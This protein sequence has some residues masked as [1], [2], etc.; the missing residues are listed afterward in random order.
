[1]N[2]KYINKIKANISIFSNRKTY[3]ILD[4]TYKSVYRGKSMNFENLREYVI[5]D[6]IKDIDWKSS[7]RN[8]TLLVK[9][10]IAEKKHNILF[11]MDTGLKMNGQT[12]SKD[13][14]KDI[15]LY[16]AGTI[17]YLAIKNNDYIGMIYNQND[18]ITFKKFKYNLYNLEEYLTEYDK[19]A[20]INNN[21]GIEK[22]LHF[23]TRNIKKRMIIFI[24]TDLKG[25]NSIDDKTLK[26]L[27]MQN[28]VLLI[29]I[30]DAYMFGDNI[31]DLDSNEYLP[32]M[33]LKDKKLNKMERET[34]EQIYNSN[35]ERLRKNQI[36]L[37][38]IS[39]LTEINSKIIE[40]LE[41]HKYVNIN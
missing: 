3:N 5:N 37:V 7:T 24:I 1:M 40:L 18:N 8:N 30:N 15:A 26:E 28:D 25:M 13:L 14:K 4:G 19:N 32:T 27:S 23:I 22:T 17:G 35:K 34:K 38:T 12:E 39:N 41:S 16:T 36:C 31:F 6:D 11:V 21:E 2:L 29:N 10:Y 20:F 33:L 9:Q